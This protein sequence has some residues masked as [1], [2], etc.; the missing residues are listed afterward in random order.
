MMTAVGESENYNSDIMRVQEVRQNN[1]STEKAYNY[2]FFCG[3]LEQK[4]SNM[5]R[6]FHTKRIISAV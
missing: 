3:N 6:I 4:S 5:D 2:T 1:S